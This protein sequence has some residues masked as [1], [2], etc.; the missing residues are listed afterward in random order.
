MKLFLKGLIEGKEYRSQFDIPVTD[1]IVYLFDATPIK[2]L[3]VNVSYFVNTNKL[4]TTITASSAVCGNCDLCGEPTTA[5]CFCELEEVLDE[6]YEGYDVR[7]ESYDLSSLIHDCIALS[8]PS[9]YRCSDN[10]KGLC[11]ICGCNLN[12][13]SCN[14]GKPNIIGDNNPFGVLQDLLKG[15]ARDGSTKKKGF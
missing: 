12:K 6:T 2:P 4:Y 15:G 14:C 9:E 7:E 5:P 10:C 13:N 11:P 3:T 1:E 8:R